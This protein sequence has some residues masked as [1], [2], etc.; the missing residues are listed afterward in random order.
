MEISSKSDGNGENY[1]GSHELKAYKKCQYE[2]TGSCRRKDCNKYHP[3]KTCQPYSKLGSCPL[4]S[5]C[6]HRHPFGVCHEWERFGSCRSYEVCRFKHPFEFQSRQQQQQLDPSKFT[7]SARGGDSKLHFLGL[8]SP[9]GLGGSQGQDALNQGS[10]QGGY[11]DMR[12]N[13]W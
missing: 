8:G 12:G 3:K 2:N 7:R 11:H 13:R 5:S 4:E 1:N 10:Q 6:E 9:R